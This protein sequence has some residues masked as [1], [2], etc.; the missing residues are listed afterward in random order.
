MQEHEDRVEIAVKDLGLG[1]SDAKKGEVFKRYVSGT[2]EKT[3]GLGLNIVWRIVQLHHGKI[4]VFDNVPSGTVM[5]ITLP[6]D[7]KP[8]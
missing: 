2:E 7:G 1:I 6:L 8:A 5:Q 3:R 4:E